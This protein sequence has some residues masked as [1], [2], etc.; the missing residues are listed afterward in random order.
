MEKY[1]VVLATKQDL[2]NVDMF[3]QGAPSNMQV[4]LCTFGSEKANEIEKAI[5]EIQDADFLLIHRTAIPKDLF[6]DAKKLKFIQTTSQGTDRLPVSLATEMGIPFSNGGGLN[7]VDV[8]EHTIILMMATLKRLLRSVETIRQ[9]KDNSELASNI[10]RLSN[11][12]VGIVGLGNIGKNVAKML[13]GFDTNT[14]F[15]DIMAVP[16]AVTKQLKAYQVSLDTLLSTSDIVTLC[17]PLLDSTKGMISSRQLSM[18]KTSAILINT[19]RGAIV[20]EAAL[21]RVL[22]EK[23]IAGAGLDVFWDEI[24]SV[25]NPLLHMDNVIPTPHI[26]GHS[27]E[28]WLLTIKETWDNLQRVAEGKTPLN[29]VNKK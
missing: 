29:I 11:K 19:S 1:K 21:I 12:T 22:Q 26:G 4:T 28:N 18:M 20:D 14:I 25:N 24:P 6:R 23:K 2:E 7:S 5:K 15:F 10:H 3:I 13:T 16:E 8:A 9:G 27:W 17:I